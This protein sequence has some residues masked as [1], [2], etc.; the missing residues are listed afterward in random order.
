MFDRSRLQRASQLSRPF[1]ASNTYIAPPKKHA[2]VIQQE[3]AK[4]KRATVEL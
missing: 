2:R 3:H 4:Y 1:A